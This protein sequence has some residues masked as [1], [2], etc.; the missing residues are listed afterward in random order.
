MYGLIH[1]RTPY[2]YIPQLLITG[3]PEGKEVTI[4]LLE[5]AGFQFE[6][7]GIP[8]ANHG[9][10]QV[11]VWKSPSDLIARLR[12]EELPPYIVAGAD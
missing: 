2:P 5:R 9:I 8:W 1:T 10:E 12:R 6:D 3:V 11:D 7:P 4:D